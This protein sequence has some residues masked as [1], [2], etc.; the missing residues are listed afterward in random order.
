MMEE[1][2]ELKSDNL[3]SSQE[4]EVN[5]YLDELK[6]DLEKARRPTRS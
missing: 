6:N 4:S 5:I 1:L 3:S 2:A